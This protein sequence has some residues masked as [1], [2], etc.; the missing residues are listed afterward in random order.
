MART[1]SPDPHRHASQRTLSRVLPSLARQIGRVCCALHASRR[2]ACL[3]RVGRR[4][5]RM[6]SALHN[7]Q[8][9]T[10]SVQYHLT[11][12]SLPRDII[13]KRS[14][15]YGNSVCPSILPS[16]CSSHSC[17]EWMAKRIKHGSPIML[18]FS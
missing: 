16:V 11:S 3:L 18:V 12:S 13:A 6:F 1:T 17:T 9:T 5:C 2:L 4:F 15:C 14:I 8:A 10:L 7:G